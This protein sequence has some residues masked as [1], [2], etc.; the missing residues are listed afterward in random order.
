L[1]EINSVSVVGQLSHFPDL[2]PIENMWNYV[3]GLIEGWNCTNLDQ[4][5]KTILEINFAY[6]KNSMNPQ[7]T[8]GYHIHR[9]F[10]FVNLRKFLFLLNRLFSLRIHIGKSKLLYICLFICP[11]VLYNHRWFLICIFRICVSNKSIAVF[12]LE[13]F[14]AI[15]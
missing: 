1:L 8:R 15:S 13:S 12:N 10:F 3:D 2:S 4:R 11:T 7:N 14:M 6:T 5:F 9:I